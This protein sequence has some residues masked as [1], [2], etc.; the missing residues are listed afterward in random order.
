MPAV[1]S[2][3]EATPRRT[4][5]AVAVVVERVEAGLRAPVLGGG[6]DRV[7]E[8]LVGVPEVQVQRRHEA[9][10]AVRFDEPRVLECPRVPF[11][12]RLRVGLDAGEVVSGDARVEVVDACLPRALER[13]RISGH[14]VRA[15]ADDG[16]GRIQRS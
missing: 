9:A 7:P 6:A 1:R 12:G 2:R 16:I 11:E 5:G 13:G 4:S 14:A 10:D 15:E 3:P 8:V